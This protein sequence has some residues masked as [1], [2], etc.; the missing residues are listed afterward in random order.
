MNEAQTQL[1]S[2]ETRNTVWKKFHLRHLYAWQEEVRIRWK[3]IMQIHVFFCHMTV[4][5]K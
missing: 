3:V 4:S 2:L 5:L 1:Y